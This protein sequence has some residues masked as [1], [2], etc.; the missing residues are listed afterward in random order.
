MRSSN[1][2]MNRSHS[3]LFMLLNTALAAPGAPPAT[4]GGYA[5]NH[6]TNIDPDFCHLTH[7]VT[8]EIL[9]VGLEGT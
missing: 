9:N 4:G 3:S 6:Y 7:N 1:S 8:P 5:C 2:T